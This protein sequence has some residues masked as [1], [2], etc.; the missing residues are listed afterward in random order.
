[1]NA[2]ETVNLTKK[3]DGFTAVDG[4]N[5][6]VSKGE[7]FAL[8]GPNGAGKTTTISM[9]ATLLK[10][11]GGKAL[12]NGYDVAREASKVRQSIGV[13]FQDPS[14]DDQ[15]TARENLDIHGRLYHMPREKRERKIKEVMEMV[16]L[17]ERADSLVKTFSGGM[18]RRLE[19][20]RG[21]M[22]SPE[23]L[24]LDEPTLGLDPQT[25][26]H[27]WDYIKKLNREGVTVLLTTHY[28]EEADELADR[29]V[30]IDKGKVVA[31]G[32]PSALK[33]S[34]SGDVIKVVCD[35]AEELKEAIVE[36]KISGEPKIAGETLTMN[37]QKAEEVIPLIFDISNKKGI[38]VKSI[39]YKEPSLEDVFLHYTGRAYREEEGSEKDRLKMRVRMMRGRR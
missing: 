37:V 36:R 7:L 26:R 35:R 9:L 27:I 38:K 33:D 1:M 12:V 16:D 2:I 4:I 21:L 20:A 15:L 31:E 24:F 11:T 19:I 10:P 13:V 6:K 3:F 17:S 39:T 5:L 29:I 28:M 14:L 25:R 22:H 8:L 34:I 18:R 23:V 30:I 32:T